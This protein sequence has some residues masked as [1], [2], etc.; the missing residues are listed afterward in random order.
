M[1]ALETARNTGSLME[2]AGHHLWLADN[3]QRAPDVDVA[4][5]HLQDALAI[6][7]RFN[8]EARSP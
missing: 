3:A 8:G 5:H 4:L 7:E 1:Q 2:A 6:R